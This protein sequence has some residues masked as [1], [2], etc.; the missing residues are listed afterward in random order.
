[1]KIAPIG[2]RSL[3]GLKD[4]TVEVE[5]S[6]R[7]DL[8][9]EPQTRTYENPFGEGFEVQVMDL[10]EMVS[11]KIRALF[12]RGHPRDLYDL[13]FVFTRLGGAVDEV[14]VAELIPKKIRPPMVRRR[15][16][17]G[18]LYDRIEGNGGQ[19]QSL[20]RGLVPKPPGYEE[21]LAVV[22]PRLRFLKAAG[23]AR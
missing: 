22:Q 16:D 17:Y 23:A 6:F 9:L 18:E 3:L 7:Q 1:L 15:W 12:Q 13:W 19:W 4:A 11:E 21:A 5:V 14:T 2:Y 20:L 10:N 8:V